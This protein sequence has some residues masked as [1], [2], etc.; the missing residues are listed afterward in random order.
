[1]TT[2]I[3]AELSS[4]PSIVDNGNATAITINSS[5]TVM[6]GKTA[7]NTTDVG[8]VIGSSGYLYS[9]RDGNIPLVLNRKTSDG[10]IQQFRKDNTTIGSVAA[11]QSL[12]G[13]GNGDAGLLI[14]GSVDA[15]APYNSTTNATRDAAI[16]LGTATNR[17]Q[18]IFLSGGAYLGGTGSANYLDDYE[19]GEWTPVVSGGTSA[20][21]TT[22]THQNGQYVKVGELVTVTC[23]VRYTAATGSGYLKLT[24]LPYAIGNRTQNYPVAATIVDGLNW[25]GGTY[26]QA[27]SVPGLQETNFYYMIDDAN[28]GRQDLNNETA[29]IRFSMTYRT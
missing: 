25:G 1:M 15:V 21:T 22:H 16:N 11:L 6:V 5:E 8:I 20:G 23:F 13:I 29:A 14:A 18:N 17:F 19:E 2:K 26:L 3:P 4:T 10:T 24:G 7:D 12:L 9:T 28:A 27:L